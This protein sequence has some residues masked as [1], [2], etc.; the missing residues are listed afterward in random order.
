M[1]NGFKGMQP[2]GDFLGN[3][4]RSYIE[5]MEL[6]DPYWAQRYNVGRALAKDGSVDH[7]LEADG[8]RGVWKTKDYDRYIF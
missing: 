7:Y 4:H 8:Y 2:S 5:A 1:M 6:K 3:W